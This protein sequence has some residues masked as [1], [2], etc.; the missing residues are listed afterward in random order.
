MPAGVSALRAGVFLPEE[1]L[2]GQHGPPWVVMAG[3]FSC[4][5]DPQACFSAEL[6]SGILL[7]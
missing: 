6:G 7:Q 4:T 1:L 5:Q 2:R 3:C